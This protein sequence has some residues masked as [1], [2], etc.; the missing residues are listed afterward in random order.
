MAEPANSDQSEFNPFAAGI[1]AAEAIET[2]QKNAVA[3]GVPTKVY[4]YAL[5]KGIEFA[6]EIE[7]EADSNDAIQA[8]KKMQ[9]EIDEAYE[10]LRTHTEVRSTP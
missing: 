7:P 9:S 1:A 5:L 10:L 8:R 6:L 3:R 4:L 2:V